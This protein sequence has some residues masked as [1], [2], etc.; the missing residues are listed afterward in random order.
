MNVGYRRLAANIVLKAVKDWHS[1]VKAC[2]WEE[3]SYIPNKN[4]FEI[5]LFF[6]SGYGELMCSVLGLDAQRVL[7][8]LENELAAA[9]RRVYRG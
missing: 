8:R 2:A 1:L 6:K 5:R 9:K 3:D 4:F 7:A